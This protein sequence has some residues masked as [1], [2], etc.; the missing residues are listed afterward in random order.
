MKFYDTN[1][2]LDLQEK[3]FQ[4]KFYI[5]SVTLEE[6][7]QIKTSS[8][9]DPAVKYS[10][11]KV[12]HLLEDY[13]NYETVI[14]NLEMHNW[15]M[16]RFIEETPDNKICVCA[17]VASFNDP[18]LVFVT[19]DLC[20]KKI[21][22]AIFGL[23]TAPVVDRS[24]EPYTGY[25]EVSVDDETLCHLYSYPDDNIFNLLTN[26][27]LIV[28]NKS[29]DL[30]DK[31]K[32]D[33]YSLIPVQIKILK[34]S[35]FGDVKPYNGDVYQQ[36]V[37]DSFM[38][39][40]ITMVRGPA[41]TGK[42]YLALSYLFSLLEKNKIKKIIMFCNTPKTLN[43]VGLGYYPGDKNMKLLDSS[44]GN[45]LS[46]KLG[47]HFE[48]ERLI[49][50]NIIELLPLSDLRGFDTKDMRCAVY[51]TEAQ[52]MDI[53]LMKL[54]LQRIGEDSICIIDGDYNTQ[55]DMSSYAGINNGMRR[56]SEVYRGEDLYG[57]VELKNIYRGR[58]ANIAEQM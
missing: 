24:L 26:Q 54:A 13:D 17:Y 4:E 28:R 55:V 21:A 16:D 40:Q 56:A 53:E 50:E 32:W 45:M 51:I 46:A 8:H 20:C 11:R 49:A 38:N 1:A 48:V 34:S 36:L 39:N 5:S 58:I 52:N 33:G 18:N 3:A 9:K 41:G 10:A 31:F 23:K 30:I 15:L 29:G 2:L 19:G 6:L 7:E 35:F 22:T 57:E 37:I 42:S 43:S 27:Y 25:I 47:G 14:Y 12:M 44:V